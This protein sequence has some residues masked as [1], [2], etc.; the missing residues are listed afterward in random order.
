MD[1]GGYVNVL[2]GRREI[3]INE[4]FSKRRLDEEGGEVTAFVGKFGKRWLS[5]RRHAAR[6]TRVAINWRGGSPALEAEI[7]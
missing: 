5:T 7:Y 2:R 4:H 6:K 1:D 3:N